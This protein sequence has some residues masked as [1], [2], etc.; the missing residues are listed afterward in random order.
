MKWAWVLGV[1]S[2]IAAVASACGG[3]STGDGSIAEG[4]GG[5]AAL[6]PAC[7]DDPWSCPAGQTCWVAAGATWRCQPAGAANEGEACKAVIGQPACAAGLL[8]V[9]ADPAKGVCTSFCSSAGGGHACAGGAAC[10]AVTLTTPDG[11]DVSAHG[12]A[13]KGGAGGAGTGSGSGGRGGTAG[14]GNG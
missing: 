7:G 3:K 12:C 5:A 4:Q 10:A 6:G 8:C 14:S 13:P 1:V 9:G 2:S 11:K